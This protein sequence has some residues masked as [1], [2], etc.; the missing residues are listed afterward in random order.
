MHSIVVNVYALWSAENPT[1]M[2]SQ[3]QHKIVEEIMAHH[4]VIFVH[5]DQGEEPDNR[6][7]RTRLEVP[8]DVKLTSAAMTRDLVQPAPKRRSCQELAN[9]DKMAGTKASPRGARGM[10][11]YIRC[12]MVKRIWSVVDALMI[13][14]GTPVDP[15]RMGVALSE[16]KKHLNLVGAREAEKCWEYAYGR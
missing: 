14:R 7:A 3:A 8:E 12:A 4:A 2:W 5:S 15:R 16:E 6:I 10:S 9:V 1:Q 11:S 13:P